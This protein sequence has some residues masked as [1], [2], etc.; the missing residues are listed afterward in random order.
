M[1]EQYLLTLHTLEKSRKVTCSSTSVLGCCAPFKQS[2]EDNSQIDQPWTWSKFEARVEQVRAKISG[3][4]DLGFARWVCQDCG[5]VQDSRPYKLTCGLRYC[6]N[7]DCVAS[8][9]RKNKIRLHNYKIYSKRLI[10]F[11]VGFPYVPRL[12]LGFKKYQEMVLR[13][14]SRE[15]KRLGT[16]INALRVFDVREKEGHYFMHYHFAQ[17]PV[18][19]Y[20]HFVANSRRAQ[21]KITEKYKLPFT[22]HFIGWREKRGLFS[23]FAKR[24]AGV[25]GHVEDNTRQFLKDMISLREYARGF[26]NVR[27]FVIIG[28]FPR[29]SRGNV[30]NILLSKPH[31]CQ[32]C[33]SNHLIMRP[34]AYLDPPPPQTSS[35]CDL[36][37]H[38]EVVSSE[39]GLYKP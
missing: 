1:Q 31:A 36:E 12:H 35:N 24:M 17:M 4:K 25:Y 39:T 14:F 37:V 8:R 15:M 5:K 28:N 27:S 18:K 30:L 9:I 33:G 13:A 7:P 10:H 3:C 11:V 20:M 32:F 2:S 26:F 16:P 29:Q 19:D 38:P 34:E 21:D 22:T 23:Y 6:T